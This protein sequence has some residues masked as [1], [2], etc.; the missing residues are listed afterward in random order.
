MKKSIILLFLLGLSL[1]AFSQERLSPEAAISILTIAPGESLNDTWGHSAIRVQ[2]TANGLDIVFNYGTYDFNTPNFYTKFMRGQLLFDLGINS[3]DA[4][5]FHYSRVN[6]E[7]KE[8]VLDLT[9]LE[10]QAY[11]NFLT[12][13]AK[14]AN[15]KYLYDFF[16]DNCATKLREVNTAILKEKVIYNDAF[17]STKTTF[18]ELIYQK[19]EKHPWGK[20][21]ID[22][23]L[24]S[25]I[26]ENATPKDFSFLPSYAFVTFNMASIIRD[27]KNTPLIKRTTILY[28]QKKNTESTSILYKI[29]SPNYIFSIV[30]LLILLLTY[31]DFQK[32]KQTKI[33]DFLLLFSTGLVGLLVFLLWFA[34]DHSTTK[35][36]YNI[37]WAFLPNIYFAFYVY[38]PQRENALKKYYVLL[39]LL[40]A[41]L[42]IFWIWK[43]QIF[44]L[45][46]IPIIA[47]LSGRYIYNIVKKV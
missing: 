40:L 8:Q 15:R 17:F 42:L 38:K 14:P 32:K 39:L 26:D 6:R 44:N 47:M 7:V 41:L 46:F 2:D 28:K 45:A 4:F 29:L 19:L 3:F 12:N 23:A 1:L 18:R 24:G 16:F 31:K 33:I 37:L 25:V 27:G 9:S 43:I 34:T 5:L 36:N 35:D 22:I 13:N 10:K 20:F 11:F 30:S 21:G